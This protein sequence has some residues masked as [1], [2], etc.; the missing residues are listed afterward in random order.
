[1]GF[2][3]KQFECVVLAHKVVLHITHEDDGSVHQRHQVFGHVLVS[4]TNDYDDRMTYI[5][6]VM[7][8]VVN[9]KKLEIYEISDSY[10]L[11]RIGEKQLGTSIASIIGHGETCFN[12]EYDG[13]DS[14]T[15]QDEN[16]PG[17]EWMKPLLAKFDALVSSG[18]STVRKEMWCIFN[19]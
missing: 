1:M 10:H 14:I 13:E 9:Q 8:D 12:E 3:T 15:A 19:D 5:Q 16:A 17:N 6:T 2:P 11:G 7:M 4:G 18:H